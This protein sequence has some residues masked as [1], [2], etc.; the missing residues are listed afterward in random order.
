MQA[1]P[2]FVGNVLWTLPALKFH[3]YILALFG[4]L[5]HVAVNHL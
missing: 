2:D 1:L 5:A 3:G 4:N